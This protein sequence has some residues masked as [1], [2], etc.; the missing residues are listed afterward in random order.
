MKSLKWCGFWGMA[1]LVA[2][3]LGT[4]GCDDDDNG[5]GGTVVVVVTNADGATTEIELVEPEQVTPTEDQKFGTLLLFT[6]VNVAFEWTAVPGAESYLLYVNDLTY[7][8]AGT[9]QTVSLPIGNHK[10]RV[11]AVAGGVNG[12][13]SPWSNFEVELQ[14]LVMP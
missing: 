1:L 4:T 13:V 5:G 9:S 6:S 12:P 10:W 2:G 3:M 14:P 11:R 8:V 7:S